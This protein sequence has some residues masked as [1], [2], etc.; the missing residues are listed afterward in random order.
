LSAPNR[1]GYLAALTTTITALSDPD[2]RPFSRRLAWL[3]SDP[4]GNPVGSAYLTLFTRPSQAHLSELE[5]AVHPSERRKGI[6]SQ[7]VAAAADAAR[8]AEAR[9]VLAD[10]RV[11]S[12]ADHFLAQCGFT[13]GLRLIFTRLPLA[14][15]DAAVLA[16]VAE[17]EH[18]GYRL[19]SW[20]GVVPDELGQTF[21]EARSAM[22][23]APVGEIDYG[24]DVWDLDRTKAAALRIEQRGEHLSTVAAVEEA[25]GRIVGF[26][27]LV[28]PAD[29]RGDA[30][31][32]S[33]AVL[34]DHRGHGLARWLKA[35]SI[36]QAR[37]RFPNLGGLL[38]D[39]VDTN[40][41]MRHVNAD[42]GYRT[43]HEVHR[44]KLTLSEQ[45]GQSVQDQ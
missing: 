23:D 43:T 20:Q 40:A 6:G 26:T 7:L 9:I 24:P 41:A 37:D 12:P 1:F 16:A 13:V 42:L 25:T 28:V 19:V 44:Y 11:G 4:D 45:T 14:D 8:A 31:N 32:F 2:Y 34:K 5:L 10:A 35:E 21:T 39:M 33:T 15:V 3:A 36:R 30:Q 27:E 38:T 22:D 29:G 17:A 18:P